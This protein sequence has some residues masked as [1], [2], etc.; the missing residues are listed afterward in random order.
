M[1]DRQSDGRTDRG[2]DGQTER[3]LWGKAM[4]VCLPL[5]GVGGT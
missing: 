2:M 5:T 1:T 4:H 3:Q